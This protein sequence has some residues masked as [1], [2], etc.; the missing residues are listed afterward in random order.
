[1]QSW[2]T[3]CVTDACVY[4]TGT[5]SVE[6]ETCDTCKSS[7]PTIIHTDRRSR[8]P[9]DTQGV[10]TT[11]LK[12]KATNILKDTLSMVSPVYIKAADKQ[13]LVN[14]LYDSGA[15]STFISNRTADIIKPSFTLEKVTV[16]TL[17]GAITKN[18]KRYH[19][20]VITA[21]LTQQKITIKAYGQDRI[22][23]RKEQIP[24][25]EMVK[26]M[27]HLADIGHMITPPMLANY[28]SH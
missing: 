23:L 2:S 17:N 3:N 5:T 7:H 22:Y 16:H 26:D 28:R 19:D 20:I 14:L 18:V 4:T 1:M 13:M 15:D 9:E 24:T 8:A 6:T 27:D 12:S 10:D 11:Q 21:M 25:Q